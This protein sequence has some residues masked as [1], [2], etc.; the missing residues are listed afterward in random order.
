MQMLDANFAFSLRLS[1]KAT[2]LIRDLI[3][4]TGRNR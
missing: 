2:G 3:G 1:G 4:Q